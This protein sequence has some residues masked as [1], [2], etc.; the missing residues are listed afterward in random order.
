LV[1]DYLA[2]N[3]IVPDPK[4]SYQ[5]FQLAMNARDEAADTGTKV[6]SAI[7]KYLRNGQPS[8]FSPPQEAGT[9]FSAFL[10]W[11]ETN[12]LEPVALEGV[13]VSLEHGYA[14]TF[15]ML[16]TV[17]GTL[18][19]V[20][21]KTAKDFFAE[22]VMQLS[23][24]KAAIEEMGG[25]WVREGENYVFKPLL[26]PIE[27]VGILRLDKETGVPHFKAYS[28][29]ELSQALEKFIALSTYYHLDQQTAGNY[30]H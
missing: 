23:A 20:D 15:D 16:A 26:V 9:A 29:E 30:S 24:Y 13:V 17:D 4:K 28:E 22:Y 12:H 3:K 27:T 21:F 25:Y 18:W 7:E 8:S 14:G 6:H 1:V 2:E 11:L 10:K 19:L 5:Y